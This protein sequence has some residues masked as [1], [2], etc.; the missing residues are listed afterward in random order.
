MLDVWGLTHSTRVGICYA[1]ESALSMLVHHEQTN[2]T[3]SPAHNWTTVYKH[4][5]QINAW[6]HLNA[7]VG[8]PPEETLGL[9]FKEIRW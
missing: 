6:L 5:L 1:L 7:R 8:G 2:F 9:L 4:R 3:Y